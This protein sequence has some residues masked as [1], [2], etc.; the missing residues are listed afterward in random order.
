[1]QSMAL[2]PPED[3][4]R[5]RPQTLAPASRQLVVTECPQQIGYSP[6]SRPQCLVQ[7]D[8]KRAYI[9]RPV[10]PSACL[11]DVSWS[12]T[13]SQAMPDPLPATMEDPYQVLSSAP[14]HNITGACV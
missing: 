8:L 5:Y 9:T 11:L 6:Y 13:E 2:S 7:A 3:R 1:M 14:M 10:R 12:Y 4:S